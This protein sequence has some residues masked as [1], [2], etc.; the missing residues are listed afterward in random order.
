MSRFSCTKKVNLSAMSEESTLLY[1]KVHGSC[2]TQFANLRTAVSGSGR[3]LRLKVT[4]F[5]VGAEVDI[6]LTKAIRWS[7][8]EP[9]AGLSGRTGVGWWVPGN[10]VQCR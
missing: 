2:C 8:G 10:S 3:T 1:T 7:E 9:L 5:T 4:L 6:V